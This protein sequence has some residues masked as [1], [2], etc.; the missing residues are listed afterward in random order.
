M[1]MA[2][3]IEVKKFQSRPCLKYVWHVSH[4]VKLAGCVENTPRVGNANVYIG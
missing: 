2:N 3:G 4:T 1:P